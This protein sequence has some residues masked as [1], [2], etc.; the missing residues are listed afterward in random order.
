MNRLARF[1]LATIFFTGFF[2]EISNFNGR[3][4]YGQDEIKDS[5]DLNKPSTD[6]NKSNAQAENNF[7]ENYQGIEITG[8]PEFI[9]KTK[10]AIKLLEQAPEFELV[11]PYLGAIKTAKCSGMDI[12][13]NVLT[14]EVGDVTFQSPLPWYA[15]TIAHDACHSFVYH[16]EKEKLGGKEPAVES[17]LGQEAERSCLVFQWEVL[18]RLTQEEC[19]LGY[20]QELVTNP[21]YQDTEYKD[22]SW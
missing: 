3:D 10:E 4:T 16:Q 12:Y 18:Q 14:Y 7:T 6:Q 11:R 8:S 22:R 17:W 21:T 20:L 13:Q 5:N 9:L 19:M 1:I 2:L 15:S